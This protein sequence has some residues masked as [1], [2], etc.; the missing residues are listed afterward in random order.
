MSRARRT[1][2]NQAEIVKTLRAIP[3]ISVLDLSAVASGCPDISVGFM[4]RN[5]FLEIKREIVPG[6][7]F[8]SDSK[9]NPLQIKWHSAWKGQVCVVR[10]MDDVFQVLGL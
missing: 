6:K 2:E 8:A 3:G 10:T 7:V 1:D 4:G 5:Y 9:L